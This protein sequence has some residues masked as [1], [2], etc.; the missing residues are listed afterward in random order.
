MPTRQLSFDKIRSIILKKKKINISE[1]TS[2]SSFENIVPIQ[3]ITS[4]RLPSAISLVSEVVE[5]ISSG[6]ITFTFL[7]PDSLKKMIPALASP[8][9]PGFS[10]LRFFIE[11]NWKDVAILLGESPNA[12][13]VASLAV[14]NMDSINNIM[15]KFTI[16]ENT[17]LLKVEEDK[18]PEKPERELAGWDLLVEDESFEAYQERVKLWK[19]EI[20][21]F[22]R[23]KDVLY[24]L[25]RNDYIYEYKFI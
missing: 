14:Q 18:V 23:V 16:M 1:I 24:F 13:N 11:D 22:Q 9:V 17:Q 15:V 19:E 3:E 8:V 4:L 6:P 5:I 25:G 2:I 21:K 10:Y 7:T 12:F 20:D